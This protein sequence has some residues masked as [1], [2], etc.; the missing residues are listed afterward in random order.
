[1]DIEAFKREIEIEFDD[2]ILGGL[3]GGEERV[4]REFICEDPAVVKVSAVGGV[5]G[6]GNYGALHGFETEEE[7]TGKEDSAGGFVGSLYFSTHCFQGH[8]VVV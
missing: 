7:D 1:M 8:T 4:G 2:W 5:C 6:G 3:G